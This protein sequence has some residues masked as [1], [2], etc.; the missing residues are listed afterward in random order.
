MWGKCGGPV[1]DN[2]P[3]LL[4]LKLFSAS[5]N[6]ICI[7]YFLKLQRWISSIRFVILNPNIFFKGEK[8]R[9]GDEK[10]GHSMVSLSNCVNIFL[11]FV[12]LLPPKKLIWQSIWWDLS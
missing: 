1:W 6:L 3:I 2:D 10:M 11:M 9:H 7:L 5:K 12:Q 8:V 4:K